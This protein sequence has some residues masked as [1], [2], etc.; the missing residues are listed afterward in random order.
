MLDKFLAAN[1]N[2]H[3]AFAERYYIRRIEIGSAT[4]KKHQLGFGE[5][6]VC[7]YCGDDESATTFKE[8]SHAIPIFLGNKT[9]T[10]LL[11][12]DRCNH[13]FG[14]H[15]ENSFAAY[16]LP[17]RPFQRIRGRNGIP[18][19]KDQEFRITA[20]DQSNLEICALGERGLEAFEVEGKNQLRFPL[21]RQPYY[22]TAIHKSL[23]KIALAMMPAQDHALFEPLKKWLLR[24]DHSPAFSGSAPIIEWMISGPVDPN[25]ITCILAK[26]KKSYEKSTFKFQLILRY[27]NFQYQLVIP[28]PEEN[29]KNKIR[30][31]A[32]LLMPDSHF[33]EYGIPDYCEKSFNSGDRVVGEMSEVLIQYEGIELSNR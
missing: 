18:K 17:H 28:L 6:K 10:D 1:M 2:R 29:G 3:E 33:R 4:Q 27:G 15:F 19:Y 32:P 12:C 31:F 25:Q 11:E 9:V 5:S 13:H 24:K 14:D 16:T 26:A 30:V 21:T 7:R 8:E 20:S 23:V 22:P